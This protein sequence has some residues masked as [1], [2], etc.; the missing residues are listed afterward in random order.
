MV[1][2]LPPTTLAAVLSQVS[3]LRQTCRAVMTAACPSDWKL[4]RLVS[5]GISSYMMDMVQSYT[6]QLDGRIAG[7]TPQMALLKNTRLSSLKVFI[8]EGAHGEL[9]PD[10]P[11]P[12]LCETSWWAIF[13]QRLAEH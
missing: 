10:Q 2:H 9:R 7:L 12:S 8:T 5:K 6:L 4:L 3:D 1:A 13:S 11:R